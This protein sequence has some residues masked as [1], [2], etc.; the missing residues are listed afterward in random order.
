MNW[1][2]PW[3]GLLGSLRFRLGLLLSI[4]ILPLGGVALFQTIAVVE[5]ARELEVRDIVARTVAAA[6][7]E[8]ALLRRAYGTAE[9]LGAV[10]ARLGADNPDCQSAMESVAQ[11]NEEY[12][13]VG[14][15]GTDGVMRCTSNGETYDFAES[16]LWLDFAAAPRPTATTSDSGIA[17]GLSA[18]IATVPV[19]DDEDRWIGALSVSLPHALVDTLFEGGLS[20]E[21]AQLALVDADGEILTASTGIEAASPLEELGLVPSELDLIDGRYTETRVH[22]DGTS[23]F[24]VLVPLIGQRIFVLG[25]WDNDARAYTLPLLGST[26][27]LFPILMWIVAL[28]VSVL[29]IDRLIL[30]HLKTLQI[31]MSNFAIENPSDSFAILEDPPSELDTIA[32][33][34]NRMVD[35]ILGDREALAENVREKEVLLREVHHRVKNNLQL[36]AS[37]LNMQIRNVSDG[38][39]R[40]VLRRVQDR[41]MSLS[42]I[43]KALYTGTAM[44]S[45][46]ADRLL[47]EVVDAS[48]SVGLPP[49]SGV[50]TRVDLEHLDLDPDQAVPLALM[51]TEL[52]TNSIKHLGRPPNGPPYLTVTLST[53]DGL[54]CLAVENSVGEAMQ[55]DMASDG[56]GLGAR[57]V[58]AFVSQLGG[59]SDVQ[60][61]DTMY[62]YSMS[63]VAFD[64]ESD[65]EFGEETDGDEAGHET[66]ARTG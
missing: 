64:D 9:A 25:V 32:E 30:R 23:T 5:D 48:L 13:F 50:E 1:P 34:Y 29:A 65:D 62:R 15:V 42:M 26:A 55:T 31:R 17:S 27:T 40:V 54:T 4:A 63:F 16:E 8:R 59:E 41:V 6:N 22:A 3:T 21:K 52:V 39:A 38:N 14:F 11:R 47:Q 57:L 49:H 43:H 2:S 24:I 56:T 35:R 20:E 10:A 44:S 61:S 19:F 18:L 7:T 46:R 60:Q 53:E 12:L 28:V 37:I 36:I 58:E 45:V 51:T 33:T 66:L